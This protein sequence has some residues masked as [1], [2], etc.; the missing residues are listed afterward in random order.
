[1]KG[2]YAGVHCVLLEASHLYSHL[3]YLPMP[4]PPFPPSFIPAPRSNGIVGKLV[5][6]ACIGTTVGMV[7]LAGPFLFPAL[8]RHC[9][10]FVPAT[11]VQVCLCVI[12]YL[13]FYLFIY[14]EVYMYRVLPSLFK[15]GHFILFA[16]FSP[17]LLCIFARLSTNAYV[18]YFELLCSSK[19]NNV[20]TAFRSIQPIPRRV[21]DLGSGDGRVVIALAKEGVHASGYELNPWLVWYSRYAVYIYIYMCVFTWIHS[22][23]IRDGNT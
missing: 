17:V 19:V 13:H 11:D 20:L 8:R 4:F 15:R 9:L 1:M 10:P 23:T 6:A 22:H 14:I 18:S 12:L 5:A 7:A 2:A 3:L 16:M 21:A